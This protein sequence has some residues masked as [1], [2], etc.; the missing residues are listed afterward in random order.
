MIIINTA[1]YLDACTC[2]AERITVCLHLCTDM[3]PGI[4]CFLIINGGKCRAVQCDLRTVFVYSIVT[5]VRIERLA[6][7]TK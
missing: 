3:N 4:S 5:A 2:A 6:D 1:A 7:V